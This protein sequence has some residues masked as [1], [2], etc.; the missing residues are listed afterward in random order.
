[1]VPGRLWFT[2]GHHFPLPVNGDGE[3][4]CALYTRDG[5]SGTTRLWGA[6]RVRKNDALMEVIG[7]IDEL[8]ACLGEAAARAEAS[9]YDDWVAMIR[10]VQHDLF[11]VSGQLAHPSSQVLRSSQVERLEGWIDDLVLQ[12]PALRFFVLPGGTLLSTSLHL[13]RTVARRAERRMV[14]WLPVKRADGKLLL[15]YTNRISDWLFALARAANERA[16][17]GNIPHQPHGHVQE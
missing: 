3:G 5:D 16:G 7:A 2:G 9:Q 1:M 4:G 10:T 8:N 11:D 17:R 15:A 6:T 12:M 13:A 14:A